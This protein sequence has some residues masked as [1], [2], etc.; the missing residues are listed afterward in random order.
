MSHNKLRN[1]LLEDHAN[2]LLMMYLNSVE[3]ID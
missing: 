2:Q 3:W 1:K